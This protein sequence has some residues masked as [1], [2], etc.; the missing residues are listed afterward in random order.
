VT[1]PG[2]DVGDQAPSEGQAQ[3]EPNAV[4]RGIDWVAVLAWCTALAIVFVLG[5]LLA[6]GFQSMDGRQEAIASWWKSITSIHRESAPAESSR[7]DDLPVIP[8][9][10]A[11]EPPRD[12]PTV[13]GELDGRVIVNPSWLVSP[14]PEFPEL[15]YAKGAESGRV[16]LQCPVTADGTIVSCWILSE[17]PQGAGFGQA[18]IAAAARARLQPR[19]VDGVAT[20]GMVRFSINFRL[21]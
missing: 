15:A 20:G 11:G 7:T 4:S 1:T 14:T 17:T 9:P 8:A 21:Q 19:T 16:Q 13:A 2:G 12:A 5:G 10:L 6:I 3:A 18:A